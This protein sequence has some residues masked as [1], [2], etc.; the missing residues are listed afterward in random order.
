MSDKVKYELWDILARLGAVLPPLGATIYFFPEW[1][2]K[3]S[4]AT[5]SGM[6]VVAAL[7]FMIPF[8]RKIFDSLKNCTL[9][10]ESMPIFWIVFC[11]VF[12]ALQHIVYRMVYIGI[13]GL[14]GSLLSFAI[15]IK[16]NQ[17]RLAV[18]KEKT[19]ERKDE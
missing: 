4:G 17:Y 3:S 12:F 2:Q 13:A 1:I 15:C 8:W 14:I 9:T 19:E 6:I 7:V 5:F 16:R 18:E 11:G 10:N